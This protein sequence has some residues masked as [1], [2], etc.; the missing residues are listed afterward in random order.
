MTTATPA[1]K[2]CNMVRKLIGTHNGTF[3]CDEAL[4]VYLLGRTERFGDNE[5][6]RT[7]DPKVLETCDVVVDVGGV[8]DPESFRFDHHQRGFSETFSDQFETKL[9]SAGLVYKHFGREIIAKELHKDASDAV[10]TMLYEKLYVQFIEALDA[11]DNGIARYPKDVQPKYKD[12]TNLAARVGRL[13]PWWN[14]PNV[15]LDERFTQ[16]VALTGAEFSERV[17][18]YGL[19]WLPAYTLVESAIQKRFEVDLSG[20]ILV[21]ETCCPWKDHIYS[22]EAKESLA[23]PILYVL[24]PD[25]TNGHWRVQCVPVEEGSFESRKPLPT[26]WRGLRDDELSAKSELEGC[27]FVHAS[28]FIGGKF[29]MTAFHLNSEPDGVS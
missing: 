7:R 25:G 13:N 15:D 19:S 11:I 2:P 28:G 29:S 5:V 21:L 8:Y 18:Y 20:Q 22:I 23:K 14:E 10:V 27:V 26:E 6:V 16:A 9:S 17:R 24:Y 4:A 3:H 1:K 12:S